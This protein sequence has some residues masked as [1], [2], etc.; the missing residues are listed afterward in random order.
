MEIV[1]DTKFL[2]PCCGYQTLDE[3]ADYDIC[4]LCNWE[5]DG[6]DD[7]DANLVKSGPNSDY[8]LTEARK[9]FRKYLVIYSPDRDMRI[10]GYDSRWRIARDF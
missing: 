10:T 6:Q 7:L 3:R 5:Y 1:N 4:V 8:S 9:N 2:C